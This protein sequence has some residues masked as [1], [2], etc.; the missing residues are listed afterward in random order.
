MTK[1]EELQRWE[2]RREGENRLLSLMEQ[3]GVDQVKDFSHDTIGMR[4][5]RTY[6][7]HEIPDYGQTELD[8]QIAAA[9]EKEWAEAEKLAD[10]M[11]EDEDDEDDTPLEPITFEISKKEDLEKLRVFM[12]QHR[13]CRYIHHDLTC[14]CFTYSCT[15]T[16]LGPLYS[17]KCSCGEEII[18]SGDMS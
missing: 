10:L 11:M 8:K 5:F 16:G 17:V 2:G 12:K 18:L 14:A 13:R 3:L 1:N 4:L 7:E 6:A 15:P 9:R